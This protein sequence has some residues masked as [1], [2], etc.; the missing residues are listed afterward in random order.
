ML[1]YVI[2]FFSCL[3]LVGTSAWSYPD[4]DWKA[5]EWG[6]LANH[7]GRYDYETVLNDKRIHAQLAVLL[8]DKELKH[9][10]KNLEVRGGMGFDDDCLALSGN[11]EHKGGEEEA[12]VNVCLHKGDVRVA[13]LSG[14][15]I[16]VYAQEK[17][18]YKDLTRMMRSWIYT[19]K[20]R[21]VLEQPSFV[22]MRVK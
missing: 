16:M 3:L 9:L 17:L 10:L 1:K 2:L 5:G 14:Q 20:N 12:F 11:A 22:E 19:A 15:T 7:I 21:Q 18:R 13:I 8:N 6:D 4:T